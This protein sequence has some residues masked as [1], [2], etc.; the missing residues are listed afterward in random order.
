MLVNDVCRSEGGLKDSKQVSTWKTS[1]CKKIID[2]VIE[3]WG[4]G[5]EG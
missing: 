4:L 1:M 2:D 5:A 3:S